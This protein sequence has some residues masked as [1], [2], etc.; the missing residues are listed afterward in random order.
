M[1]TA[2]GKRL[3]AYWDGIGAQKLNHYLIQDVEHPAYNAQ[4]VLIRSFMV[5]RLFP[6][7]GSELIEAELYFSACAC[8][9]LQGNRK[10][11]FPKLYKTLRYQTDGFDLPVFLEETARNHFAELVDLPAL[12]DQLAISLATD[13]DHFISP[14]S[15]RWQAFLKQKEIGAIRLLELGCGSANDYRMWHACGL[16]RFL[17]YTG[18]DVSPVNIA[19]ARKRF[20]GIRFEVGDACA[21]DAPDQAF[22]VTTAFDLYEHLSPSSMAEAIKETLRVTRDECWLAFFNAHEAPEHQIEERGEYHWN[23]L[24]LPLIVESI[25]GAGFDAVTY[26]VPEILESR[27]PGY[28]HYNRDAYLLVATRQADPKNTV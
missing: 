17:D 6:G 16:S 11:W 23:K 26:H 21:I 14:F 12:C 18:M 22:D 20:P 4:S 10:G 3:G 28:E 8:Y 19:N 24:S 7:E 13:F 2:E 27:F 5:D 25:T 9:A 1:I 15:E